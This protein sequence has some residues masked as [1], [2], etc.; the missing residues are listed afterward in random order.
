MPPST[1][2]ILDAILRY[3]GHVARSGSAEDHCCAISAALNSRPYQEWKC[4]PIWQTKSHLVEDCGELRNLIHSTLASIRLGGVL[5]TASLGAA[6]VRHGPPLKR[7][8]NP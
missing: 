1:H 2:V 8:K 5:K 4:P 3:S 6:S 7:K